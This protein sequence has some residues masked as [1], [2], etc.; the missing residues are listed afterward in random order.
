MWPLILFSSLRAASALIDIHS[1]FLGM[2]F[3]LWL[4]YPLFSP[5][6]NSKLAMGRGLSFFFHKFCFLPQSL[7][8]AFF[9]R[10]AAF[11]FFFP[12]LPISSTSS[13]VA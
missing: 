8:P 1:F 9:S 4:F 10:L 13:L 6:E 3:R 11:S 7:S 5:L 12:P 2:G